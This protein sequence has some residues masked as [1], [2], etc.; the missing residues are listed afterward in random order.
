MIKHEHLRPSLSKLRLPST[1]RHTSGSR[2]TRKD[3]L[4][5]R[6]LGLSLHPSYLRHCHLLTLLPSLFCSLTTLCSISSSFSSSLSDYIAYCLITSLYRLV[7]SSRPRAEPSYD[8]RFRQPASFGYEDSELHLSPSTLELRITQPSAHFHLTPVPPK[9]RESSY[10]ASGH[11]ANH[12]HAHPYPRSCCSQNAAN[13]R[14]CQKPP[15]P[16]ASGGVGWARH[17]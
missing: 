16:C 9:K 6:L 10:S 14:R 2:H 3:L 1:C 5:R 17:D 13:T 11:G 8:V 15:W 12:K 4:L 7:N